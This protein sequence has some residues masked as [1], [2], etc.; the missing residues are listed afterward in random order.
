MEIVAHRGCSFEY[1]ENSLAA[2]EQAVREGAH[3]LELDIRTSKDGVPF[4]CHDEHTGRISNRQLWVAQHDAAELD[5]VMRDNGEP[6]LRFS[7]LCAK[8]AGQV[9]LDIELK[10]VTADS[11]RTVLTDLIDYGFNEHALVTSF[12]ANPLHVM[13]SAGYTGRVGLI[14]GSNS[15]SIRQR[16]YEAWPFRTLEAIHADTLVMHHRLA[17]PALVRYL[18]FRG[19]SLYLWMTMDDER[20]PQATR[21]RYYQNMARKAPAG[22]IVGRVSEAMH[23]LRNKNDV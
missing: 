18:R 11:A 5:T 10:N 17:H 15:R 6:L 22:I 16:A 1:P 21:T 19:G 14:V 23:V 20:Q 8:L 2:F 4:V 12:Y 7:T 9:E 3:R 13:R